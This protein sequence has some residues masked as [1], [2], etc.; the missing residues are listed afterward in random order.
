MVDSTGF[1]LPPPA[2]WSA[3]ERVARRIFARV[4][5]CPVAAMLPDRLSGQF[6]DDMLI[7][8]ETGL[9]LLSDDL[10]YRRLA[11]SVGIR[12]RAGLTALLRIALVRGGIDRKRY[13][14]MIAALG[15]A[16]HRFIAAEG[17][18]FVEALK[19]DGGRVGPVLRGAANLFSGIGGHSRS[20]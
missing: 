4:Y 20:S 10:G 13:I 3:F 12:R 9:L 19:Q 15:R 8:A 1:Q 11:G 14:S 18:D 7:A 17:K 16:R 2:D 5:G 6:Q